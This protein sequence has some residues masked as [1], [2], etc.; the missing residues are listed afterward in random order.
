MIRE[1]KPMSKSKRWEVISRVR[2]EMRVGE[3]KGGGAVIEEEL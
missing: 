2:S 3:E 1:I